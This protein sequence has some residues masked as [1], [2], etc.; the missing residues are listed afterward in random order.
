MTD[1][2]TLAQVAVRAGV[3]AM[4][5]SYT[6]NQPQRVSAEARER[7]LAA[8]AELGYPGPDPGARSLR[9]GSS[10]TI[11]VVLG[12]QLTY[13]FEDPQAASFLAGVAGVCAAGGYG[14]TIL[15]ITGGP[16]DARRIQD[17]AVDGFI[18]W[19]T[20]DGDPVLPAIS[21]SRRPAVVHGGPR[22]EGMAVMGID[23]EAAAKAVGTVAFRHARRPAVLSF[24]VDRLRTASQVRGP[25]TTAAKI[26]FPVT[27]S[28]LR[29]YRA[30]ARTLGHDWSEV[31]VATCPRNSADDA[32]AAARTLLSGP[33]RPD[34]V[35]AMSDQLA[36][37]VIRVAGQ[38][39]ID[40]PRQ[41]AITGFDD[42]RL[43]TRLRLTTVRQSLRDQ[44]AACAQIILG[45]ESD[46]SAE[47]TV[48]ER[49][50]TRP[51]DSAR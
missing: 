49:A 2:V 9:R 29:G 24:P 11:G 32:E 14:M 27:R 36:A 21:A 10:Q 41:L 23:D 13:A 35:A 37:G 3:S 25:A 20:V 6:Y 45:V 8:A 28:R 46:R 47:W 17:A 39:G 16:D 18:V 30:A 38:L 26:P 43:A 31:T 40:I 12:E 19:T 22:T 48:V 42:D 44:G 4:T 33:K 1:R 34:A 5:A 50:S 15:P 51:L 7:V